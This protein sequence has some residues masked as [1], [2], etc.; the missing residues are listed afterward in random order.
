VYLVIG[1][2]AV[3]LFLRRQPCEFLPSEHLAL[4]ADLPKTV[5]RNEHSVVNDRDLEPSR[6][7]VTVR[8]ETLL[9]KIKKNL[10]EIS[11]EILS[12]TNAFD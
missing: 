12:L 7:V 9:R 2:G 10:E 11:R 8:F 3:N 1:D 4:Y 6:L 5:Q